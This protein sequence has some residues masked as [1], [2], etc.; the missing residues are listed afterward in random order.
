MQSAPIA[1]P[2]IHAAGRLQSTRGDGVFHLASHG[3]H[4]GR[5]G[6]CCMHV[7]NQSEV[8]VIVIDIG[9]SGLLHFAAD[10]THS[11]LGRCCTSSF[12]HSTS[13]SANDL[14]AFLTQWECGRYRF[15]KLANILFAYELQVSYC[16]A[17]A[18]GV[19]D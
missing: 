17:T 12:N 10:E 7:C 2:S 4:Q 11:L 6:V 8:S 15:T 13:A 14:Q 18:Y 3:P 5:E 16:T 19:F 1:H 9:D